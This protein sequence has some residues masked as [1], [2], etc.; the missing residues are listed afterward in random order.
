MAPAQSLLLAAASAALA[1][2]AAAQ[3]P[4]VVNFRYGWEAVMVLAR[5]CALGL[6]LAPTSVG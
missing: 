1:A 6:P 2:A 3:Q 4:P 5:V